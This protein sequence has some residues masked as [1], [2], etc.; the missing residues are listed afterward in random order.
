MSETCVLVVDDE[1]GMRETLVEILSA[2]GYVVSAAADGDAALAALRRDP[3]DVVLMDIRM[4]GRDGVSV[5]QELGE[6]PPHVILMTA[7][8]RAERIR[9]G[10]EAHAYAVMTK[11]FPV[12]EL[13]GLVAS[14]AAT[15]A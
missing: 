3:F 6:P 15:P 7:Y 2:S 8:A 12:P 10:L 4:P 1:P 13:L 11:P 14:A 9:E 5:L